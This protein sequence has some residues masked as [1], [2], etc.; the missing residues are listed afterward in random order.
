[1]IWRGS[2]VQT[3]TSARSVRQGCAQS[4]PDLLEGA[5][6]P[7]VEARQIRFQ[8]LGV[9]DGEAVGEADA[10]GSTSRREAAAA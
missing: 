8:P 3:V 6:H 5:A 1:V 10:E 9:R 2:V 7:L 4:W